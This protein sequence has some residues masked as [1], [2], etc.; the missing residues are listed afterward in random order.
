MDN[1]DPF[2]KVLHV[3]I[4]TKVIRELRDNHH[5]LSLSMQA[6]VLVNF[7]A[8][9]MSLEDEELSGSNLRFYMVTWLI[10]VV[11]GLCELQH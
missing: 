9:M 10:H 3:P 8:V 5:S 6:F 11:K 7:L 1:V 2:M 4:M